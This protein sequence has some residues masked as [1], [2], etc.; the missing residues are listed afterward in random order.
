MLRH[1]I[2]DP[3]LST[4]YSNQA[5][6]S[7]CPYDGVLQRRKVNLGQL[8]HIIR[9][10]RLGLQQAARLPGAPVPSRVRLLYPPWER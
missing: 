3:L 1:V 4:K 2:P 5:E 8:R 10:Q 9:K 6:S 7:R